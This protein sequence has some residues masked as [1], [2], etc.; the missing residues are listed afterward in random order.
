M[1]ITEKDLLKAL[2]EVLK[3]DTA[4]A[5]MTMEKMK[6]KLPK[7][8]E[9]EEVESMEEVDENLLED[10][11]EYLTECLQELNSAEDCLF[12]YFDQRG[13]KNSAVLVQTLDLALANLYATRKSLQKTQVTINKIRRFLED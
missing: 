9:E 4:T 1:L 13:I 12:G 3:L 11:A 2:S 6:D 10:C 5:G 8:D 7:E